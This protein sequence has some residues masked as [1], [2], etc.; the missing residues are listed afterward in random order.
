EAIAEVAAG[1]DPEVAASRLGH[2]GEEEADL[3]REARAR[4]RLHLRVDPA[5]ILMP[6]ERLFR[7]VGVRGRRRI[8]AEVTVI[9]VDVPAEQAPDFRE[10]GGP[11]GQF[12][13]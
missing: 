9:E 11:V 8:D 4:M 5:A 13:K 1:N 12:R 3:E 7:L 6:A 2:V 10:R